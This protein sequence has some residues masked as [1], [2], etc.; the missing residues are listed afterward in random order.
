MQM[1][2]ATF[3]CFVVGVSQSQVLVG[4]Q[5]GFSNLSPLPY[6]VGVDPHPSTWR[7][8]PVISAFVDVHVT[9]SMAISPS[10]E[11]GQHPFNQYVFHGA[12]IPEIRI[13]DSRGF[14]SR[15]Y[16][17]AIEGKLLSSTP[18]FFRLQLVS[19]LTYIYEDLGDIFVTY[20][21]MN[22]PGEVERKRPNNSKSFFAHS[23]GIGVRSLISESI[24]L[25][26]TAKYV[27]NYSDRFQ[28][29]LT[30]GVLLRLD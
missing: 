19:G 5:A 17:I 16:R 26:F 9:E 4:V 3:L 1:K 8:G 24:G 18:Q 29:T 6:E 14:D 27:S 10:I 7:A 2:V 30:A 28:T 15:I 20:Q 23:L 11:F 12:M 21:D 22:F 13:I 25:G